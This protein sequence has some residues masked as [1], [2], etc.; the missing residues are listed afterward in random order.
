MVYNARFSLRH[1]SLYVTAPNVGYA[2]N[3]RQNRDSGGFNL[4]DVFIGSYSADFSWKGF[5]YAVGT[6]A[7]NWRD[8]VM[9]GGEYNPESKRAQ[10]TKIGVTFSSFNNEDRSVVYNMDNVQ[11]GAVETAFKLVIGGNTPD[12]HGSIEGFQFSRSGGRTDT[13]PWFD[14]D[15]P[16]AATAGWFPP[17]FIFQNCNMEGPGSLIKADAISEFH[18]DN[19]LQYVD[20]GAAGRATDYID[21][22][23]GLHGTITNNTFAALPGS[24]ISSFIHIGT[25]SSSIIIRDNFFVLTSGD[26]KVAAGIRNDAH[27]QGIYAY[28][29]KYDGPPTSSFARPSA[30]PNTSVKEIGISRKPDPE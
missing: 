3:I 6:T 24:N 1:L 14:I 19:N 10:A 28:D 27:D 18:I 11:V 13:G 17:Y 30:W 15:M 16:G 22:K 25:L 4:E 21:I 7:T 12:N 2:I 26:A 9:S 20:P 29:N 8:V 23:R 5:V